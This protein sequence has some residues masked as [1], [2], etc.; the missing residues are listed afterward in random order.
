MDIGR[1]TVSVPNALIDRL[2]ELAKPGDDEADDAIR[3]A[4]AELVALADDDTTAESEYGFAVT[5]RGMARVRGLDRV[6]ALAE[7]VEFQAVETNIVY[8]G[9]TITEL[10]FVPEDV[11]LVEIDGREVAAP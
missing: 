10:S 7:L 5:L 9:V 3:G 6:R 2:R 8:G 4:V 1:T 11:E